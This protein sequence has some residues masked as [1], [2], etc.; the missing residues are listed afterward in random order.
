MLRKLAKVTKLTPLYRGCGG[1]A[2]LP[3]QLQYPD[4]FHSRGGCEIGFMSSTS[5]MAVARQYCLAGVILE[6]QPGLVRTPT[7]NPKPNFNSNATLN[8][9]PNPNPKTNPNPNPQPQPYPQSPPEP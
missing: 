3:P 5:D 6:I 2:R 9:N 7:P 1:G 8:P 4:K